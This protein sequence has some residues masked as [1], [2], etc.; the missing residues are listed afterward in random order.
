MASSADVDSLLNT[1]SAPSQVQRNLLQNFIHQLDSNISNITT[2][3]LALQ[4]SRAQ[5]SRQRRSYSKLLSPLRSLPFEIFGEIFIYATHD[6]AKH[7]LNLSAVCQLWR[8]AA[9]RTPK[10]WTTLDLVH[11]R[12]KSNMNN[13]IDSWIERAH[14]YPLS[15]IIRLHYGFVDPVDNARTLL[16]NH[17]WKSIILD[18]NGDD[19]SIVSILKQLQFAN[20]EMLERFSL[21]PRF[22]LSSKPSFGD[23]LRNAPRLKSLQL[24][25]E[26]YDPFEFETLPFPWRQLTSLI[27]MA[28]GNEILVDV[29]RA[30]VN[31]EELIKDG[32]SDELGSSDSDSITLTYL[33][34]LHLSFAPRMF[35]PSLKTPSM[36]DFAIKACGSKYIY[37]TSIFE[38]IERIGGTLLKLSILPSESKL[39]DVIPSL[40]SLVELKLYDNNCEEDGS[41]MALEILTCLVVKPEMEQPPFYFTRHKQKTCLSRDFAPF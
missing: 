32:S 29:L 2:K 20:L 34:K 16:P 5:L 12:S 11:F 31:L 33:R 37:N 23:A 10:L 17:N 41:R 6:C 25:I 22:P 3:I 21:S 27:L 1:N 8:D 7:V 18:G 38:Y 35:L 4:T 39:V 24:C 14:S 28:G 40:R 9:L 15:L 19:S 26:G 30:C 13:H 36:Q